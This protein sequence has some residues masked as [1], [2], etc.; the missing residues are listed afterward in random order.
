M[1][2]ESAR[3]R[4]SD[5]VSARGEATVTAHALHGPGSPSLPENLV[6]DPGEV[7]HHAVEPIVLAYPLA[8]ACAE[9]PPEIGLVHDGRSRQQDRTRPPRR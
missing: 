6:V 2:A 4:A 1:S 9:R 8:T 5:A 7:A 3:R